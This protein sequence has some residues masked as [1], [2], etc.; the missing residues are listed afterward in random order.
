MLAIERTIE[1]LFEIVATLLGALLFLI[2]LPV[3]MIYQHEYLKWRKE[4][5]LDE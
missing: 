5:K 3:L 2:L 1:A 4:V